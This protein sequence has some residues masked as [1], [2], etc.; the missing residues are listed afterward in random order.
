MRLMIVKSDLFSDTENYK[1]LLKIYYSVEEEGKMYRACFYR[2]LVAFSLKVQLF[3]SRRLLS[4]L[5]CH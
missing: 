2:L 1:L 5:T 4:M 3:S